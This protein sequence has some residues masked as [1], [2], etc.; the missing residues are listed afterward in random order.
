MPIRK[1]LVTGAPGF[2]GSRVCRELVAYGYDV[3]AL[4]R[5]SSDLSS[6]KGLDLKLTPGDLTDRNSLRAALTDCDTVFHIAAVFRE[7]KHPDS[8][9]FNVNAEGTKNLL[10]ESVNA[11][12][13]K[14][15]HCSTTGVH[16]HIK[17]PPGN[18]ET[19]FASRDVY[20]Q[21]KCV[22]EKIVKQFL[23]QERYLVQSFV[24]L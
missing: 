10:E 16:G 24:L 7:A 6:L 23:I 18:E 14:F 11:G 17:N 19:V 3:K 2:V 4:H 13:E 1:V 20:Q 8:Y 21:S 5:T 22:A 9:Y 15:I 12:V